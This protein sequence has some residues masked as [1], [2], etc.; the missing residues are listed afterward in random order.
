[1]PVRSLNVLQNWDCKGCSA[2]CRQYHVSVSAD[3]RNRIE[4]HDW[5]S[6][7]GSTGTL[8]FV[9]V[10]GW[11]SSA[12]RLNHRA[13]GSC[14]FLGPDNRCL[15][16]AKFGP[17]AKPLACRIYPYSLVPAGDHWKLGLRFACPSAVANAGRPLGEHL[18]EAREYAAAL[19]DE[20][21]TA[22]IA[23]PPPPLQRG[24]PVTWTDFFR[25]TTAFSKLMAD[26]QEPVERRWRKILFVVQTLRKA[27][28]DGGGDPNKAVSAGRLS[29]LLHIL[30]GAA[31]DEIPT[32]PEDVPAPGWV[33]RTVF[34]SLVALYVRKDTGPDRGSAQ[35][36][37][38][39][40]F[41]SAIQFARGK[42]R[43][44]R[45]HSAM[46]R[47]TFADAERPFSEIPL[48]AQSML[49]RWIRVKI[50]SG[51]FCGPTNF[52]LMVWEGLESLAAAFAA[53]MWLARV[54][55]GDGRPLDDAI[56]MA[57]RIVDDNFGFNPLLGSA[58]Q[59]FALRLLASRGEL[60]KLV[61]WYGK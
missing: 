39:K 22:A 24:Q 34:R 30:S 6:E 2:C 1:L 14:V 18:G 55:R 35:S 8:L 50:E 41:F 32:S 13:D 52:R 5:L 11:F 45:T 17:E 21:G 33:G 29:E 37:P 57:V 26:D 15:I 40:R 3:E 16:H 4:E 58:R 54:L 19:E 20:A 60:S 49:A 31:G 28:F 59:K 10:G 7:I 42:G 38:A 25:I 43:V 47:T 44:P 36:N 56:G 23:A 46:P 12:Y 48:S 51:Q 53:A 9:R 27:T 61:A